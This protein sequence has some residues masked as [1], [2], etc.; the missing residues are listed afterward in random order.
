MM[1]NRGASA[2]VSSSGDLHVASSIDVASSIIVAIYN[3][4]ADFEKLGNTVLELLRDD[5]AAT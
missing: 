2:E 4:V 3:T 1:A 5:T